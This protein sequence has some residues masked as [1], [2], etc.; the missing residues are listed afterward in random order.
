MQCKNLNEVR[1]HIDKLDNEI[2]QK[3]AE[4]EGYVVQA[5]RFKKASSE[6]KA[7]RRVEEVIA[8]VREKAVSYGAN[9]DLV[10]KIYRDMID[11]FIQLEMDAFKH[12]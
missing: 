1:M 7:E 2:V 10:E 5:A 4:R 9:Q 12:Q 8:A 3:I 6:V 11:G